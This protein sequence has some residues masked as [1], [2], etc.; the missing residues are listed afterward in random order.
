MTNATNVINHF[1]KHVHERIT[2][3]VN[4]NHACDHCGK[5][6]SK[7]QYPR[8]IEE[9]IIFDDVMNREKKPNT[10]G[11]HYSPMFMK[12]LCHYLKN[13]VHEKWNYY[14]R[15]PKNQDDARRFGFDV[16]LSLI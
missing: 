14:F 8:W 9:E 7:I 3:K 12:K 15:R 10:S 2:E 5:T 13:H 1:K 16:N 4:Y 11:S 6:I